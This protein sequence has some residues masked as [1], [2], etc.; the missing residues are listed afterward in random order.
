MP[1]SYY[2]NGK[3]TQKDILGLLRIGKYSVDFETGN[4][5]GQSGNLL[6]QLPIG[7]EGNPY[8]SLNLYDQGKRINV[9]VH[10]IVWMAGTM[11]T[12][13]RNFEIHH[14]DLDPTNNSFNN[15]ICVH[16]IDHAKLHSEYIEDD[17]TPF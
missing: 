16:K 15:L 11:S 14:R 13:P 7:P 4:I 12:V 2:R 6:K 17:E 3:L 8:L 5:Y 9:M 10:K 1:H